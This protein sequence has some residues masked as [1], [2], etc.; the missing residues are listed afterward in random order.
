MD[1]KDII[2]YIDGS[3]ADGIIEVSHRIW[4]Y[5]ELSLKETKSAAL[6]IEKLKEQGFD[7]ETGLASIG[8]AFSGKHVSGNGR[9]VIGILGEFDALSGLSQKASCT[10]REALVPGGSGHG[11]ATTCWAQRHSA[12]QLR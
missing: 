4:E 1:R 12:R 7:V 3:V 11:W 9:P 10:H 5:A 8:T 2:N 6:Y